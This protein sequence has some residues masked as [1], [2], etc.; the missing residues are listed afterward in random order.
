MYHILSSRFFPHKPQKLYSRSFIKP[1]MIAITYGPEILASMVHVWA[2]STPPPTPTQQQ[3]LVLKVLI[4]WPWYCGG[5]QVRG[6][7]SQLPSCL[8]ETQSLNSCFFPCPVPRIFSPN[9]F[10]LKFASKGS[11]FLDIFSWQSF[12]FSHM[13]EH[14]HIKVCAYVCACVCMCACMHCEFLKFTVHPFSL[15]SGSSSHQQHWTCHASFIE[16]NIISGS[17]F[18]L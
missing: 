6:C 17:Q 4:L 15:E 18:H 11:N 2:N 8:I 9:V 16:L 5:N 10:Y 1:M 14:L 13:W 7:A 3:Q 12:S